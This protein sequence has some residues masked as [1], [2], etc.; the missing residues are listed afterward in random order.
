MK[1][2][3]LSILAVAAAPL[4]MGQVPAS[5]GSGQPN[6]FP[7]Y[8]EA[9]V[10][11]RGNQNAKLYTAGTGNDTFQ[12]LHLWGTPYEKGY[13]QGQLMTAEVKAVV[14]AINEYVEAEILHFLPFLP[15]SLVDAIATYGVDPLLNLTYQWTEPFMKQ[16]YKDEMQGIA[17]GAGIDVDL[18]R[19]YNMFPELTRAACSIV[20]A[21]GPST[22]GKGI[23]HLRALDIGPDIPIKDQAQVT[24]YHS[25]GSSTNT[26]LTVGWTAMIGSLTG[27]SASGV[28]IGEKVW[29]AASP[30]LADIYGEPWMFVLR[31]VLEHTVT[32]DQA[33][34]LISGSNRTCA[35]HVGV[36]STSDNEFRGLEI[37]AKAFNVYNSTSPSMGWEGHP[38]IPGV[39]YWDKGVQPSKNACL[40]DLINMHYGNITAEIL[41]LQISPIAKTGDFHTVAFDYE[42]KIAFIANSR[43]TFVTDGED[44]AYMRQF[45][46]VDMGQLFNEPSP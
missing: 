11:V 28:G 8:T 5:C 37:A 20:G 30:D 22:P 46:R 9:P 6:P 29:W 23:N 24:V 26:F 17:D 41:A 36:G 1:A 34:D 15:A 18:V 44:V 42:G 25:S 38:I 43:K 7:V 2:L 16:E 27:Y 10:F 45:T 39:L 32:I 12:V 19:M 31:N 13:A 3:L 21:N 4:A 40:G 14:G 35:I 33:L